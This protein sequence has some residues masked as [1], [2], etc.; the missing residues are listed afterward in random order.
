MLNRI[1]RY[2]EVNKYNEKVKDIKAVELRNGQFIRTII[3]I[4]YE[5]GLLELV[6]LN[7]NRKVLEIWNIT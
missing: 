3:A 6:D 4:L 7:D 1:I 5:N 2:Q